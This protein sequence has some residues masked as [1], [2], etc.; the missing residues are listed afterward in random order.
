MPTRV[1]QGL[2]GHDKVADRLDDREARAH[3]TLGLVLMCLGPAEVSEHTIAH[4]LG[5]MTFEAGDLRADRAVVGVRHFVAVGSQARTAGASS[6]PG[7][8]T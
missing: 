3:G 4:Q 5:H 6:R 7:R 1:L 8:R 2:A